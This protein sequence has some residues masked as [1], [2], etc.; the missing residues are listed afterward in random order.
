MKGAKNDSQVLKNYLEN[1]SALSI[2]STT[3]GDKGSAVKVHRS[4]EPT[5]NK[6]IMDF[7]NISFHVQRP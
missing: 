5:Q 2:E 7:A 6:D 3:E 4:P 1:S